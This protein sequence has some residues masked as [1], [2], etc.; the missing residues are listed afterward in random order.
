[1]SNYTNWYFEVQELW[2]SH[3]RSYTNN[4][5]PIEWW[6]LDAA[7]RRNLVHILVQ[8]RAGFQLPSFGKTQRGSGTSSI[9]T[10]SRMCRFQAHVLVVCLD[11]TPLGNG[12]PIRLDIAPVPV[13]ASTWCQ[14]TTYWLSSLRLQPFIGFLSRP[15]SWGLPEHRIYKL[16]RNQVT[17][18]STPHQCGQTYGSICKS[19]GALDDSNFS[20]N[21]IVTSLRDT[22][23]YTTLDHMK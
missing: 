1:M 20:L 8:I 22:S 14:Y 19:H 18:Y 15:A 6:Y 4:P 2:S 5:G 10:I 12:G 3:I 16:A 7:D 21:I 13:P 11:C 9:S 23:G 17:A